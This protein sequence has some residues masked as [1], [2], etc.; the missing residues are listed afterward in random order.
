MKT[1]RIMDWRRLGCVLVLLAGVLT[2]GCVATLSEK[3]YLLAT[4]PKTGV[5]NYYR[6][7]LSGQIYA[8]QA[9]YSVGLYDR[10]AVQQLFGESALQREFLATRL[11][12]FAE[13]DKEI[14]E[15]GAV[16]EKLEA[17]LANVRKGQIQVAYAAA[18]GALE[19]M[20]IAISLDG[21][22]S[23]EF[24]TALTRADGLRGPIEAHL[25]QD[26]LTEAMADLRQL[27]V[28]VTA[29]R[30]SVNSEVLV[31]F[32]D[33]DGNERDVSNKS[34]V[35]FVATDVS[36]FTE[37]LRQLAESKEASENIL[38]IVMRDDIERAAELSDT[39]A[40]DQAQAAAVGT[41][42]SRIPLA[43]D[44][45]LETAK[46]VIGR[47]AAAIGGSTRPLATADAIEAFA[48]GLEAAE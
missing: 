16:L 37:A 31:R 11:N 28:I 3:Y 43:E 47:A 9:K 18:S 12:A 6:V 35:V 25:K 30:Q 23:S 40:R 32:F 38:R 1:I 8:S 48:D 22:L 27:Q 24:Q 39:L 2:S 42:L 46:G 15:L 10:A 14:A 36:R 21:D 29:I 33:G 4:D 45:D 7:Q 13:T 26:E 41:Y 17:N 34:E 44:A 19:S 5:S 20:R